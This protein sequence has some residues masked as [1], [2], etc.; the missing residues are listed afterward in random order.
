LQLQ[1]KHQFSHG[2]TLQASYTWS[3]LITD[4]NASAAGA[5][6]ATPGNVLSG[7][8]S[9]NDPLNR[10]Q[11][12]GLAAFNRP[13]RFVLSY[14]YQIPY[15]SEGWKEKAFGGWGVSGVTTIQ[16]GLPFSITD[17]L[18][19][20]E[21]TLLY[22]ASLPATGPVD[23]AELSTPVDCNAVTGNCKS[24]VSVRAPGNMLKL[25]ENSQSILNAGAF[26]PAPEFGGSPSTA[27]G[28][29]NSLCATGAVG[30]NPQFIGCG[31]GFG[32][33][34][35]GIASCCTQLNFDAAIIKN[36]GIR[37]P[38][39]DGSLQFRAEFFNLWNHAQFNEPGNAFDGANFGV[40]TSSAVPGRIMQFGLKYSF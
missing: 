7:S 6:I 1:L 21:A 16:D 13:Q 40:I 4:I 3:K 9:S 31:T 14:S 19:G 27:P 37:W 15:K 22:G 25:V 34:G 23:R 24:G 32:N 36:T 12:Y 33:S 20:N 11:Q 18:S 17:G 8:A 10:A 28:P 30:N 35:V 26:M 29:Y 39:E 38:R 5:G 2:L